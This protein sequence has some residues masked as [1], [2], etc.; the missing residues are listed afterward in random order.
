M[1]RENWSTIR[2]GPVPKKKGQDRIGQ[3][4]QES[5]KGIIFDLLRKIPDKPI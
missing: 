5:H 1:Q 4:S 2:P 3:D